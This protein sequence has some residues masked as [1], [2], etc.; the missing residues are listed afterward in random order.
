MIDQNVQ[1]YILGIDT[2]IEYSSP[3]RSLEGAHCAHDQFSLTCLVQL[4]MQ[5]LHA[6]HPHAG[7][8]PHHEQDEGPL[9]V[10]QSQS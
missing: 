6:K 9:Q 1:I 10:K 8:D 2:T 3:L 5:E 4:A 7:E